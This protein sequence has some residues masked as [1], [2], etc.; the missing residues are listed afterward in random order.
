MLKTVLVY[1]P[2]ITG[3]YPFFLELICKA[4]LEVGYRVVVA[5]PDDSPSQ[6]SS[7]VTRIAIA[8]GEESFRGAVGLAKKCQCHMLFVCSL[9][10]L[11]HT[12]EARDVIKKNELE[13]LELYGFWIKPYAVIQRTIISVLSK[14]YRRASR[15]LDNLNNLSMRGN[16]KRVFVLDED[17]VQNPPSIFS[18]PFEHVPDPWRPFV[19][20][21]H[22]E[23]REKLGLPQDKLIVCHLGDDTRRKG[24]LDVLSALDHID[25]T[26]LLLVRGG[27]LNRRTLKKEK[28][29]ARLQERGSFICFNRWL[30]ED[31]F[32]LIMQAAD[33]VLMPYHSH[34]G[35][36]GILS[37]AT[38]HR[39]PVIASDYGLIG[40]R[41]KKYNLGYLYPHCERNALTMLLSS[42]DKP[43]VDNGLFDHA[44]EACS[45]AQTVSCL[46]KAFQA[47][48]SVKECN[49]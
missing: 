44:K 27:K 37:R 14:G 41:V 35:S 6:V 9:D 33:Y 15:V 2:N 8:Q 26:S 22:Q 47:C 1:E 34:V 48:H 13:N 43:K 11:L 25:A 29:L 4:C 3:H 39:R 30:T 21:T 31:E 7:V 16:L 46:V 19:E 10:T 45:P 12:D 40:R 28:L 38:G 36:S 5:T 17:L 49:A 23:A 20:R 32:D 18:F 42:I 24:L